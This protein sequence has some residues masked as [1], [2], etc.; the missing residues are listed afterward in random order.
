MQRKNFGKICDVL[1]DDHVVS[2]SKW[3]PTIVQVAKLQPVCYTTP[4]S[5]LPV[6]EVP[7]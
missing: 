3:S 2:D 4:S 1:L 5:S 7:E 6:D